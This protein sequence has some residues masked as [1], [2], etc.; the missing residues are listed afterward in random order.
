MKKKAEETGDKDVE[1]KFIVLDNSTVT[2]CRN[3]TCKE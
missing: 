1:E 2:T 3:S